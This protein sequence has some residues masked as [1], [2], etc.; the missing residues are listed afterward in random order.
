MIIIDRKICLRC[1]VSP[2]PNWTTSLVSESPSVQGVAAP[3]GWED[4]H[5]SIEAPPHVYGLHSFQDLVRDHIIAFGKQAMA[6]AETLGLATVTIGIDLKGESFV[7]EIKRSACTEWITSTPAC[8]FHMN[9]AIPANQAVTIIKGYLETTPPVFSALFDYRVLCFHAVDFFVINNFN[10]TILLQNSRAQVLV[11]WGV[12]SALLENACSLIKSAESVQLILV[13]AFPRQLPEGIPVISL[14]REE[15]KQPNLEIET[16]PERLLPNL[17]K[18]EELLLYP[19]SH[20]E[21]FKKFG[22]RIAPRVLIHGPSGSGKG[23]LVKQILG[24]IGR[25]PVVHVPVSQLFSKYL[26]STERKIQRVFA[27]AY[28]CA[29][30]LLVFEDIHLL[31]GLR[32]EDED[33]GLSGTFNR[34]LAALLTG[35]DG[36]DVNADVAVLATSALGPDLLE[37]AIVRP[38]RLESWLAL[39]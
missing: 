34:S 29:P 5:I 7:F 26:G 21:M 15:T 17:A 4:A 22:V 23:A 14:N 38:G 31:V 32:G 24:R 1:L 6:A 9:V 25:R 2:L 10:L 35:L 8:S 19:M 13:T 27:M 36:V 3:L 16:C 37:P 39:S 12:N 20:P 11:I 18:L 30:S 28:S 33:E